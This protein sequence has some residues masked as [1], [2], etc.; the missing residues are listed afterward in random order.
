[1]AVKKDKQPSP[2]VKKTPN[3]LKP[4]AA[5]FQE[6]IINDPMGTE[7]DLVKRTKRSLPQLGLYWKALHM[8]VTSSD[9]WATASH[10][11]EELKL[12]C[13]YTRKVINMDTSEVHL[14]V[15]SVA[16]EAMDH[17]EFKVYMDKALEKLGRAIGY[18]PLAFIDE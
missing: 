17:D 11:H 1:M 13:G 8:A 10:L 18:D 9:K 2:I 12:V 6:Q 3:G 7:Y 5:I 16:F 4:V 14:L 15:D